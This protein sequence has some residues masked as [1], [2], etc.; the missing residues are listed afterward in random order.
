ML[1]CNQV[2]AW[3]DFK[4]LE[5]ESNHWLPE[6]KETLFIKRDRLLLNKN[7]YSQELFLFQFHDARYKF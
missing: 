7:V 4:V 1:D 6:I 3:G 2:V 5:R